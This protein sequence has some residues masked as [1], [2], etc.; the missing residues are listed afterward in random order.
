MAVGGS[1]KGLEAETPTAMVGAENGGRSAQRHEE[2]PVVT[3]LVPFR[4]VAKMHLFNLISP[5]LRKK[6][7]VNV[8]RLF[9]M[10]V[11]M[12][13]MFRLWLSTVVD[14]AVLM[15][16]TY[17]AKP[18]ESRNHCVVIEGRRIFFV[19]NGI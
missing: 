12:K 9:F 10:A 7:V 5:S 19:P 14:P 6:I 15:I 18:L 13:G 2:W 4:E 3:M 8:E 11:E 16:C 17:K 1:S